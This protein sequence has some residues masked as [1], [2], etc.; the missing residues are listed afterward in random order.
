MDIGLIVILI[1]FGVI[2]IGVIAGF[3]ANEQK[4]KKIAI[5]AMDMVFELVFELGKTLL[6]TGVVGI[7]F[8]P[9]AKDFTKA[10]ISGIIFFMIGYISKNKKDQ[11]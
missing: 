4:F 8:I 1:V 2:H 10:I 3:L 11:R 5:L 7:Y 9:D 6:M